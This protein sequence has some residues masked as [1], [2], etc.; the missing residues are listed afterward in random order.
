MS[1]KIMAILVAAT[2][3]FVCCFAA[4]NKNE[5]V[6]PNTGNELEYV[7]DENGEM[8]L[9]ENGDIVVYVTDDNGKKVTNAAGE[10]ETMVQAFIG[11]I[12]KDGVVEH[13]TYKLTLPEGWKT[14]EEFGKFTKKDESIAC[15]VNIVEYFFDDYRELNKKMYNELEKAGVTVKWESDFH[16]GYDVD[17]SVR[18][19]MET[20]EG[21]SILYFFEI[22]G[23][24]YKV[25]FAGQRSD[26]FEQ[27]TLEFVD[28][29]DFKPYQLYTDVTQVPEEE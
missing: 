4:C 6:N 5:Y 14:T 16:L 25:L 27:D 29:F 26:T 3:L 9:D 1:K 2:I 20:E 21:M 7:T 8:V 10:P 19:T 12:E 22:N 15:D 18:F 17:E 23:N 11:E 24:V 28:A 13:H